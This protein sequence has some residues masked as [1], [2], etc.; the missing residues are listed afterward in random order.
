LSFVWAIPV[1]CIFGIAFNVK[2]G[3]KWV[4]ITLTSVLC[5]SI[6]VAFYLQFLSQNVYLIF[7]AGIP[8][9]I[10]IILWSYLKSNKN[11]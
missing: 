3:K 8:I 2:W 5:W 7:V 6:C 9:Q 1:S 4:T 10:E 11:K